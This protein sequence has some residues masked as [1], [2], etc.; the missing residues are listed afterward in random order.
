MYRINSPTFK[1]KHATRTQINKHTQYK[2]IITL[3]SNLKI[4][5]NQPTLNQTKN[6]KHKQKEHTN[7]L[8]DNVMIM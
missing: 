6:I 7:K 4:L 1:Y 2:L 5:N 8:I 3:L